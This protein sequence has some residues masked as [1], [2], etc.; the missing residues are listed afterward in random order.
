[1]KISGVELQFDFFEADNID[2]FNKELEKVRDDI[3]K[4]EQYEGKTTGESLKIQCKIVNEFFDKIFGNGTAE[5]L[6]GTKNNIKDHM[7]AFAQAIAL[8]QEAGREID[9]I[10]NKYQPN[11]AERRAANNG[12]KNHG[13]KNFNIVAN[14][15]NR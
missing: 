12:N 2:L 7:E 9:R 5:K 13:K 11:R 10:V 6:F 14:N 3:K 4:P 8:S 1:M 15:G